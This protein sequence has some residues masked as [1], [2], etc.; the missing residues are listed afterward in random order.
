MAGRCFPKCGAEATQASA[1]TGA[2]V[3]Y[4][5]VGGLN[6]LFLTAAQDDDPSKAKPQTSLGQA[7]IDAV[8]TAQGRSSRGRNSVSSVGV[9]SPEMR[10]GYGFPVGGFAEDSANIE[11]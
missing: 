9:G 2:R 10:R 6:T 1:A 8:A 7:L 4:A 5:G 3:R 11:T